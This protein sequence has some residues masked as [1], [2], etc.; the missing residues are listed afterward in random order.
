M[1]E[2]RLV[3]SSITLTDGTLAITLAESDQ[4][5]AVYSNETADTLVVAVDGV[6]VDTFLSSQVDFLHITGNAQPNTVDLSGLALGAVMGAWVELGAGNDTVIGSM[7]PDSIFGGEG[8]DLIFAGGRPDSIDGGSGN[9]TIAGNGGNDSITGG[10]G[11]DSLLGQAGEDVIDS[12][13]T[14]DTV[15]GGE[16]D[17]IISNATAWLVAETSSTTEG[18]G[19]GRFGIHASGQTCTCLSSKDNC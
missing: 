17:D 5:L 19:Q 11:D 12:S 18:I 4:N 6:P 10:T 13:A 16:G 2:L 8:D 15:N 9:D 7:S 1:F 3:L 14:G